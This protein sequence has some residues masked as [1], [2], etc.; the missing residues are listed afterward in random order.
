MALAKIDGGSEVIYGQRD[1]GG[2]RLGLCD[3]IDRGLYGCYTSSVAMMLRHYGFDTDPGR[4]DDLLTMGP[5]GN[6][7]DPGS[8]SPIYVD[9]CSMVDNAAEQ[10]TDGAV[11]LVS[12][13]SYTDRSADLNAF[14]MA[15]D[16][17]I[18]VGID[19]SAYFGYPTHFLRV[20]S[21]D[22]STMVVCDPWNKSRLDLEAT[23]A[24]PFGWNLERLIIKA[25]KHKLPGWVPPWKNQ[26]APP[27]PQPHPAEPQLISDTPPASTVLTVI[28]SGRV[29]TGDAMFYDGPTGN[30]IGQ[31]AP[32]NNLTFWMAAFDGVNWWDRVSSDGGPRG[33][34]W[35]LDSKVDTGGHTPAFFYN[36]TQLP[37]RN[38]PAAPY[39][40]DPE[41]PASLRRDR[42]ITR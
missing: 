23:F 34:W 10:V 41:L 16:E 24:R 3:G 1:Y 11:Q 18:I 42:L 36:Q 15:D 31:F 7:A 4:L 22:G 2:T 14:E 20:F 25:V 17:E 32:M 19:G 39:P 35:I 26:P 12:I 33:D 37:F 21:W 40:L 28:F 8:W 5:S 30:P 38:L 13:D 29:F 27:V 9:G 6:A